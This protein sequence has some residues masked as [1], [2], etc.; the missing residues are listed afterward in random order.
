MV[1]DLIDPVLRMLAAAAFGALIGLERQWRARTAGVRTNALVALGAALFVQLGS[2]ALDG[3]GA[4]PTRVAAQIVSGIG[5]LGAGVIMKQG[6]SITGLNTAATLWASAAVGAL[7]GSGAYPLAIGGTLVIMLAN[8]VLRPLGRAL[9]RRGGT[10]AGRET[11]PTEY[12]FTVTC[13]VEAEP[14]VR[15]LVFDAVYRDDFTVSSISAEDLDGG[16]VRIATTV[17]SSERNDAAI[18]EAIAAV[19]REPAVT[20]VRWSARELSIPD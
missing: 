6:A 4:D 8:T 14:R 18:E 11:P 12:R 9:D 5:F 16:G 7:A 17:L 1:I 20:G 15:S 10:A 13:P 3:A 2:L 19:I